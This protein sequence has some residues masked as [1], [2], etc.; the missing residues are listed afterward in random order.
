M[1]HDGSSDETIFHELDKQII[2]LLSLDGR[3]TNRAIGDA[4]KISPR[5]VASRIERLRKD[6]LLKTVVL[7]D[8]HAA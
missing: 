4:L 3:T 6:K 8:M 1:L 5:Q 2:R 7:V